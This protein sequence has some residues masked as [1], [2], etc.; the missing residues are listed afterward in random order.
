MFI[1]AFD[2]EVALALMDFNSGK[3]PRARVEFS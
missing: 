3:T 2:D 1:V